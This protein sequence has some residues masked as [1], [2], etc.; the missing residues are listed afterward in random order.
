MSDSVCARDQHDFPEEKEP[1]GR[2]IMA[3]C[4]SCGLPAMDAFAQLEVERAR[5]E[6]L[7]HHHEA[8]E[9]EAEMKAKIL[10]EALYIL[11][12]QTK[13]YKDGDGAAK[14]HAQNIACEALGLACHPCVTPTTEE[15]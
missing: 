3:P 9:G 7:W 8:A 14:Y 11:L 1:S 15:P 5:A 13:P 2:F 10:R 12:V 4:L 6:E